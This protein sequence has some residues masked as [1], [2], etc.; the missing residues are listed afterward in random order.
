M[1]A[2]PDAQETSLAQLQDASV[3]EVDIRF[4]DGKPRF[5]TARVPLPDAFA[6]DPVAGALYY[7]EEYANLYRMT[8]PREELYL[9][10]LRP[11]EDLGLTAVVFGQRQ[12]QVPVYDADLA[13]YLQDNAV[14]GSLGGYLVGVRP[15]QTI[16]TTDPHYL[17]PGEAARIAR[18][19][20]T[21]TE[22]R[23]AGEPEVVLFNPRLAFGDGYEGR[24]HR[25]EATLAWLIPVHSWEE[26]YG[27]DFWE[28]LVAAESG[29]VLFA[30]NG[31]QEL[32]AKNRFDV[33]IDDGKEGYYLCG[34]LGATQVFD[35][36]GPTKNYPGGPQA[37][38]GGDADA[39][40]AYQSLQTTYDYWWGT[41]GRM[42]HKNKRRNK[43]RLVVHTDSRNAH[44]SRWCDNLN[45]SD[46]F[47][48]DDVVAHEYAHGVT[49]FESNLRYRNESGA[50][51][52]SF[53]D[54]FA[55]LITGDW[56]I[57]EDL[58][59]GTLRS[60]SDPPSE[61][62]PD[63]MDGAISGDSVGLRTTPNP[64]CG[65]GG[66]DCGF[67]HT[68]S[69]IPNLAGYLL[70]EGGTHPG[71]GIEV[72][73]IGMDHG[74]SLLYSTVR[75]LSRNADL[76]DMRDMMVAAAQWQGHT[77]HEI[78]QTINAYAAVGLG[79]PDTDCDGQSNPPDSDGDGDRVMDRDDNCPNNY[80]ATQRDTDGDGLGDDCDGDL[81]GDGVRNDVDNCPE[82]GNAN[83][84]DED[85]NGIGYACDDWDD[86]W[87]LN[88]EDNCAAV[89]NPEQFDAD[90]DGLGD[91]CDDDADDDGIDDLYDN[92]DLVPNPDQQDV[93]GDNA[94]NACDNCLSQYN[95]SQ[96]N[97]DDDDNGN[98]C[99]ADD[100]NDGIPDGEDNCQL[101]PNSRQ[102]DNNGDG[103]GTMCDGNELYRLNGML[104]TVDVLIDFDLV[105]T[106]RP[107]ELPIFPC[108]NGVM[109]PA[110]G[111]QRASTDGLCPDWLGD[112]FHTDVSVSFDG[113]TDEE[114]VFAG[115]IVNN[116]GEVI[117]YGELENDVHQLTLY[118]EP[119]FFFQ[120]PDLLTLQRAQMSAVEPYRG[121]S[122]MLQL[123]PLEGATEGAHYTGTLRIRS[124]AREP[125]PL[126]LPLITR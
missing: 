17:R 34:T 11:I 24:E 54:L 107:V 95:P 100:D 19:S 115:I 65:T 12:G 96:K 4:E 57:G 125:I 92:C 89:Y 76:M 27:A 45:F 39:D 15:S 123:I 75:A 31:V 6:K 3:Q 109:T 68:N 88:P 63:H 93:D 108:D 23:L 50:L 102:I 43:D 37:Y 7:L 60:L 78:C 82:V 1:P 118:P 87:L 49:H 62:Q 91:A 80:N 33:R 120:P 103:V 64:Q 74:Q 2:T 55:A 14:V 84:R 32:A 77:P 52:E 58:S 86:D 36:H 9:G 35:R 22:S 122:Y 99:D 56:L 116:T 26:D 98:A 83:Q 18:E 41:F 51:S 113:E 25:D 117:S 38:P 5:V 66:N 40:L 30:Q 85:G 126:F 105:G 48:T 114:P 13:V 53:S 21:A 42:G 101:V 61:G 79:D 119:E 46:N 81:D 97:S 8:S 124:W 90:G 70:I 72:E 106:D 94:G 104:D 59:I 10:S 110:P 111:A 44:Y 20:L 47:V 73:G 71:S 28:V 112:E 69:G 121:E 29:E 16:S 67:V